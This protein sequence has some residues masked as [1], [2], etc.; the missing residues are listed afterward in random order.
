M[1]RL[2]IIEGPDRGRSFELPV[3]EPQ[4]IGRSSE[5]LPITDT[6]VSRRHAELTPDDGVWYLRDLQSQNHTFINGMQITARTPIRDGD[7]IRVGSTVFRVGS[8]PEEEIGLV[9]LVGADRVESE[10]EHR[11]QSS[12]ESLVLA[13]PNPRSA[14]VEHL[15]VI[16]QLT[17]LI[18]RET[19]KQSLLRSVMELVFNEFGPE[20][21]V[22]LMA[23]EGPPAGLIKSARKGGGVGVSDQRGDRAAVELDSPAFGQP[24]GGTQAG[25]ACA[26]GRV[27]GGGG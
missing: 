27:Q 8:A 2:T 15:R 7:Q 26:G 10:I 16:Y 5:A 21:G 12:E 24:H 1:L 20:R 19:D 3:N 6:T 23:K 22:I 9:E 11:L 14:A 18:S 4:L 17:S 13:E 25:G